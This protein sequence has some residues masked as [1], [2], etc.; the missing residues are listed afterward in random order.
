MENSS[1]FPDIQ[2]P[3]E[4]LPLTACDQFIDFVISCY[5]A[6]HTDATSVSVEEL[7]RCSR[8]FKVHLSDE[9]TQVTAA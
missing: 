4:L 9:I 1:R 6:T 3:V 8:K 5:F 7:D 2:R